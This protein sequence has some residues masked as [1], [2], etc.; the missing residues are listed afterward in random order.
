MSEIPAWLFLFAAVGVVVM[1]YSIARA[2]E[3]L[4]RTVNSQNVILDQIRMAISKRDD[5]RPPYL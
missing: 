1:L 3:V 2:I 5:G 4:E